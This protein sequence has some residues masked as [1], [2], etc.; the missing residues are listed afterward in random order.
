MPTKV[1]NEQSAAADTLERPLVY[2]SNPVH[3]R[4]RRSTPVELEHS[5]SVA[6]CFSEEIG[7]PGQSPRAATA[8]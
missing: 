6:Y 8:A 2:P 5:C 4:H 1:G 3:L 7:F